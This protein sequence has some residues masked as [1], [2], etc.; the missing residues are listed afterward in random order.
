MVAVKDGAASAGKTELL[1][2]ACRCV[3]LSPQAKA[4]QRA[5]P[6]MND[7]L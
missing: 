1:F 4:V 7:A 2:A 3:V 5:T 6:V